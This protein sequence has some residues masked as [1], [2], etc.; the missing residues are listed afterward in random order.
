MFNEVLG[1][2]GPHVAQ[3]NDSY[4]IC[5]KLSLIALHISQLQILFA[6]NYRTKNRDISGKMTSSAST[7]NCRQMNGPNER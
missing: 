5:H 7:A 6:F 3:P 1:Q 2:A 4:A